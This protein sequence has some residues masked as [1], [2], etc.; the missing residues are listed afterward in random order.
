LMAEVA[1]DKA[2]IEDILDVPQTVSEHGVPGVADAG[3]D[4]WVT[5]S[6]TENFPDYGFP[7]ERYDRYQAGNS[8]WP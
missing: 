2:L 1:K 4:G 7:G 8:I 3:T 5:P 6:P